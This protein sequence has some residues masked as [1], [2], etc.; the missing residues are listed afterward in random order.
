MYKPTCPSYESPDNIFLFFRKDLIRDILKSVMP[1]EDKT[2][3]GRNSAFAPNK[4]QSVGLLTWFG[5]LQPKYA[6]MIIAKS[7]LRQRKY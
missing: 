3:T 5:E 4:I 2:Q 6:L 7:N 1:S